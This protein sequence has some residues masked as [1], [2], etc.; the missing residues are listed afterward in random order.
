VPYDASDEVGTLGA[1]IQRMKR[2]LTGK[3]HELED[4]RH[5]L[6]SVLGGMKE[7]LVLVGPDHRIRLANEAFR[8]T[9][10]PAADPHGK[11]LAE[12]IRDPAVLRDLETARSGGREVHD[13]VLQASDSGRSFELH[14]TPL[15]TRGPGGPG[16][17]LFL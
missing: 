3:I 4:E 12:V 15:G 13:L 7:G 16:G 17:V 14:V 2:S 8:Q 6:L 1:T 5:L 11:L 9:F 10:A